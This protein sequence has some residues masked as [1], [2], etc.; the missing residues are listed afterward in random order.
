[1]ASPTSGVVGASTD[2]SSAPG[3]GSGRSDD[4]EAAGAE[5]ELLESVRYIACALALPPLP[6]APFFIFLL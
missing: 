4:G 6:P 3:S 1:M 5:S 2:S